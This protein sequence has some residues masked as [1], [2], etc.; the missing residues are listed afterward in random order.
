MSLNVR[1]LKKFLVLFNL[2]GIASFAG[3]SLDKALFIKNVRT[4]IE[5]GLQ[6]LLQ[7]GYETLDINTNLDGLS[8]HGKRVQTVRDKDGKVHRF[9]IKIFYEK[10]PLDE[11]KAVIESIRKV[12]EFWGYPKI[13][14]HDPV[15]ALFITEFLDVPHVTSDDFKNQDFLKEFT[16]NLKESHQ[17]L[18]KIAVPD[19]TFLDRTKNRLQELIRVSPDL[20][21][22]LQSV[23]AFLDA[24][25]SKR[26]TVIHGDIQASNILKQEQ[27]ILIDWASLHRGDVFDDL[28]ALAEQLEFDE[29][30]ERQLLK[31]YFGSVSKGSLSKLRRHR[32]LNRLHFGLYFLREGLKKIKAQKDRLKPGQCGLS[33]HPFIER[34]RK[35]L[36]GFL[37]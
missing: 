18:A 10:V 19:D 14:W 16:Y 20:E 32:T 11:R 7:D 3:A 24:F 23:W 25:H 26:D 9:F 4:S 13:L 33:T 34:G 5:A 17:I 21:P 31:A 29:T 28:G 1:K 22:K 37:R 27:A 36:K 6:A 12:A 15:Y 35:M 8:L 2:W 30:Q